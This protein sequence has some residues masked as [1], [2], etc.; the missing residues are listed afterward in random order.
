MIGA[1]ASVGLGA[2]FR[3][4]EVLFPGSR[5]PYI[6][7]MNVALPNPRVSAWL[8]LAA[9]VMALAGAFAAQYG[10][11]LEPCVLCIYQRW[12]HA[13]VIALAALALAA[14][15]GPARIGLLG[16]AGLALLLGAGVAGY[17]VGVEQHWWRGSQACTANIGGAASL[18]ELKAQ[19]MAAPIV[20]C[21]EIAWSFLGVSMAGYNFLLSMGAGGFAL[22]AA[23]RL[24]RTRRA[25]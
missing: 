25:A 19:I 16:L 17:H 11:D 14:P 8:L 2:V 22:L 3:R 23:G 12:P 7:A 6:P 9:S 4:R 21:D 10:L 1:R 20:R 13:V 5:A 18:E 15:D 24:A